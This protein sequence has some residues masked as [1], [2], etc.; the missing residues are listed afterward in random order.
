MNTT[1][2]ITLELPAALAAE[3]AAA[4]QEFLIELLERGLRQS[5]TER[6]LERYKQG[7]ISFAA[8]ANL[9]GVPRSEFARQAYA[10]GMEPPVSEQMLAEELQ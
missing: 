9:A 1:D 2:K 5:R 4:S 3:L 7:G 8:A 10:R 6:A